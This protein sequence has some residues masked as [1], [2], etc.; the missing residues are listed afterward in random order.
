VATEAWA[1]DKPSEEASP[2]KKSGLHANFN[3]PAL[4]PGWN[5]MQGR[6]PLYHGVRVFDCE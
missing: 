2:R 5:G 4:C 1:T 6:H 3:R